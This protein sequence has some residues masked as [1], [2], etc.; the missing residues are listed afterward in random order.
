MRNFH[1]RLNRLER[2][3]PR[4]DPAAERAAIA[5]YNKALAIC[6]GDGDTSGMPTEPDEWHAATE[7]AI[8]SAYCNH[9]QL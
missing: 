8:R 6:Y 9:I 1:S 7:A 4:P 2:L 5:R 3:N